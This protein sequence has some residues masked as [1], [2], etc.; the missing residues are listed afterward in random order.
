MNMSA[1]TP[2]AGSETLDGYAGTYRKRAK[3]LRKGAR[4]YFAV[5]LVLFGAAIAAI[6]FSPLI[7]GTDVDLFR[8]AEV[9]R[10]A[11]T[12][13]SDFND[14]A[15]DPADGRLVI[16]GNGGSILASEGDGRSWEAMLGDRAAGG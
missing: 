7:V 13:I 6:W 4:A 16:V 11:I 15:L 5:A 2:P 3:R 10:A 14:I 12:Q 8:P 9:T 1:I